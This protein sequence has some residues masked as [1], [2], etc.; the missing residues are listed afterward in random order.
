MNAFEQ[1]VTQIRDLNPAPVDST[2]HDKAAVGAYAGTFVLIASIAINR[3]LSCAWLGAT[4]GQHPNTLDGLL[5][6]ASM[7]KAAAWWWLA[8]R[9]L[10]AE[11]GAPFRDTCILLADIATVTLLDT[12]VDMAADGVDFGPEYEFLSQRWRDQLGVIHAD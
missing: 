6:N 1:A 11:T 10:E 7:K 2:Q 12:A 8:L 4:V 3:A 9:S 5:F